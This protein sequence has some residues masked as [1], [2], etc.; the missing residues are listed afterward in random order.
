[1]TFAEMYAEFQS[2]AGDTTAAML[3]VIKKAINQAYAD[4][5]SAAPHHK[6][7]LQ[8]ANLIVASTNRNVA[9]PTG[10]NK[11]YQLQK[12]GGGEVPLVPWAVFNALV[13]DVTATGD[14]LK[15]AAE[16]AGQIY[17]Y[18]TADATS[19]GTYKLGYFKLPDALSAD[20]DVSIFG[21]EW[22]AVL[23]LGAETHLRT[24]THQELMPSVIEEWEHGKDRLASEQ[25]AIP[26][27]RRPEVEAG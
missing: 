12:P 6:E 11:V 3:V 15:A 24:S 18:P 8:Y 19:A 1:M 13:T 26:N 2:R 20:A 10:C 7:L 14:A 25:I 17:L 22:D 21:G 23:M 4:M 27:E 16:Q 9:V 5:A